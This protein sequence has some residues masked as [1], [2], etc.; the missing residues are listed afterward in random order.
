MRNIGTNVIPGEKICPSCKIKLTS[1]KDDGPGEPPCSRIYEDEDNELTANKLLKENLNYFLTSMNISPLKMHAV[2][3]HSRVPFCKKKLLQ[4][5]QTIKM[6]IA[7]T[8]NIDLVQLSQKDSLDKLSKE[9]QHKANDM[10]IL[11]GKIKEKIKFQLQS[12]NSIS[13][14]GSNFLVQ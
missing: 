6:R 14:T 3:S 11:I 9:V 2:T 7:K 4:V 1:F 13:K 5:Q 10:D 12:E 8:L